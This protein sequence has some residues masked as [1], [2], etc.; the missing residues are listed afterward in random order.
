MCWW[1]KDIQY[2]KIAEQSTAKCSFNG[3]YKMPMIQYTGY[4]LIY[5]KRLKHDFLFVIAV[6]IKTERLE[7]Q[8]CFYNG[9]K[10]F[11]F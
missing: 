1:V 6:L 2:Y 4:V 9:K 3:F 8:V 7:Y 11:I 10:V 5:A